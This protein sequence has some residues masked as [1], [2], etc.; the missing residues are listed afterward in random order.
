MNHIVHSGNSG[1]FLLVFR[2]RVSWGFYG[3]CCLLLL[4]VMLINQCCQELF[5]KED[6]RQASNR[7]S[8]QRWG[9]M[10]DDEG[11]LSKAGRRIILIPTLSI[12]TSCWWMLLCYDTCY[13]TLLFKSKRNDEE[14]TACAAAVKSITCYLKWYRRWYQWHHQW[15]GRGRKLRMPH[16]SGE[17]WMGSRVHVRSF[18]CLWCYSWPHC[19]FIS[20]QGLLTLILL[21]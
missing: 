4:A 18:L 5:V 10:K 17:E 6:E 1:P 9:W 16:S 13:H 8:N 12:E 20:Q 3:C 14:T 11:N 2:E 15:R 19:M 7:R 21:I